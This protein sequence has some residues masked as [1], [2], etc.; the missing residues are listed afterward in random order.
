MALSYLSAKL[1][2]LPRLFQ[3]SYDAIFS[4]LPFSQRWRLLLLQPINLLAALL[5]APYWLFNNRYSV[6]YIPTRSGTQR[7]LL[8]QPPVSKPRKQKKEKEEED[9]PRPLHIDLHGGAFIGGSPEQGARWCAYLSD[10]T[11]AVVVSC[12]YRVAPRHVFPAAHDDVDDVVSWVLDHAAAE[13]NAD[14]NLLTVGGAS[15]GANLALSVAQYLLHRRS[16]SSPPTT[17]TYTATA[18]GL[19]AFCAP[20]DFRLPPEEKPRPPNFPTRD[21]LSFLMP[22]YDAYAGGPTRQRA[23]DDARLNSFLAGR[24]MLPRDVLF[25]AA[26]VDILL[27]EQV[28]FVERVRAE[29]EGEGVEMRVWERGFHGWLECECLFHFLMLVVVVLERGVGLD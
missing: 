3:P 21:P 12:S 7:C 5:T 28:R 16:V 27:D 15:V 26:G 9:K 2:I 1:S 13:L 29:G 17:L 14:P 4:T 25:V 11:G 6:L 19:L 20:V 10:N 22:L 18:K 23:W 24:E 8:F